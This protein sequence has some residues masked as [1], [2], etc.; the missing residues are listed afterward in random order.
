MLISKIFSPLLRNQITSTNPQEADGGAKPP[1]RQCGGNATGP[2]LGGNALGEVSS[3][4]LTHGAW[5]KGASSVCHC[6]KANTGLFFCLFF[7]VLFS[8]E[9]QKYTQCLT[10]SFT[11]AVVCK[12]G[13]PHNGVG[14]LVVAPG[15]S[16]AWGESQGNCWDGDC[17]RGFWASISSHAAQGPPVAGRGLGAWHQVW[18][19][20]G[21]EQQE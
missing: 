19:L 4:P 17:R 21:W 9:R 8:W 14:A 3:A 20:R 16:P 7:L 10:I 11:R 6:F 2:E 5:T 15:Q 18:V 12:H 1:A 13:T